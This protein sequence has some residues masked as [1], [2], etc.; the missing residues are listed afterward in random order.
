MSAESRGYLKKRNTTTYSDVEIMDQVCHIR[1]NM[2]KT[3]YIFKDTIADM[4]WRI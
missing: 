1:Y 2:V 4:T 3:Y